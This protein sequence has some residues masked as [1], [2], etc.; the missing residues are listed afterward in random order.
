MFARSVSVTTFSVNGGIWLSASARSA[1]RP[2][3]AIR[4]RTEPWSRRAR[5]LRLVSVALVTAEADEQLLPVSALPAGAAAA[6]AGA[7]V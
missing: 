1:G 2:A 6:V 7:G 3:H 4:L 5:P